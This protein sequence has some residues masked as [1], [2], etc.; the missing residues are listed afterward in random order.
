MICGISVTQ[1]GV[2][3]TPYTEKC[4]I[5][6]IGPPGKSLGI[7]VFIRTVSL[8]WRKDHLRSQWEGRCLQ[9]R[10]RILLGNQTMPEPWFETSQPPN[11]VKI[12][13]CCLNSP[14]CHILLWHPKLEHWTKHKVITHY[15]LELPL[16]KGDIQELNKHTR[17]LYKCFKANETG[18]WWWRWYTTLGWSERTSL[19]KWTGA[20]KQRGKGGNHVK[21]CVSG[22]EGNWKSEVRV[23]WHVWGTE[24]RPECRAQGAGGS[25][26]GEARGLGGTRV[27]M[28]E[29]GWWEAVRRLRRKVT[30][31]TELEKAHHGE[32]LEVREPVWRQEK[33]SGGCCSGY[34]WRQP[35]KE[36][37]GLT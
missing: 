13:L 23:N 14:I 15:F 37:G 24:G 28:W 4:G 8:I 18:R 17:S 29:L 27:V 11:C 36:W 12:N 2:K 16:Y 35:W 6:T 19:W 26:G 25:S 1:L 3:H 9:A 33:R 34:K 32:C 5:L 22:R 21:T 10:K 20:K 7:R 30:F 31:S